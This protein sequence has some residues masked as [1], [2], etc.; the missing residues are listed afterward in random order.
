M[1]ARIGVGL[2]VH[3][4]ACIAYVI[5]NYYGVSLYKH[6]FGGL[7]SRGVSI[8]IAMYMV[9]YFFILVNFVI[10]FISKRSI[11]FFVVFGMVLLVFLYLFPQYPVRSVA[12][13]VL[14]GGLTALAIFA[15]K[16][17][18]GKFVRWKSRRVK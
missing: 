9:F 5:A 6:F 11:K 4:F 16:A 8:G 2:L 7:T 18:D 12:Y 13:S 14:T 15:A 1:K 3:F 17:L 10:V